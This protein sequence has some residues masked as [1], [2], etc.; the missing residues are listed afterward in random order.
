MRKF[1][2]ARTN[3]MIT[4]FFYQE[5]QNRFIQ[6]LFVSSAS[7]G[8]RGKLTFISVGSKFKSQLEALME[9]L[10]ATGTSFIRC[11]KPNVRMVAHSFEGGSVLSQLQCAGTAFF[12]NK[13]TNFGNW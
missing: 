12:K 6:A 8:S 5:C 10:R 7:S 3:H 2:T 11:I 4:Y 1:I 9:K 13:Q